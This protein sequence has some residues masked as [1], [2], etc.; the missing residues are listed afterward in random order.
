MS[1]INLLSTGPGAFVYHLL[2]FLVLETLV[3]VALIEYRRARNPDH[4]RILWTFGGLMGMRILLLLGEP[5][6][7]AVIAPILNGIELASLTLLGWAFLAPSSHRTG[8]RYLV[9]GLGATLLCT[10]T[11]LPGW[12]RALARFPY[13]L[14]LAFWQ[15]TFWYAVS[16]ILALAPALVLLRRRRGERQW[17]PAIAFGALSLGFT[18]LCMASL[19]LTVSWSDISAYTLIGIGRLINMQSYPLFAVAVHH[20]ALQVYRKPQQH[21]REEMPR[22]T[23]TLQ[24]LAEARHPSGGPLDLDSLLNRVV[25][26]AAT[27]MNVDICAIFLAN[28]DEPDTINLAAQYPLSEHAERQAAYALKRHK[29][30]TLNVETNNPRLQTLYRLL[31][32]RETGPTVI[33]PILNQHRPLGALVVGNNHSQ[34][35]FDPNAIRMCQDIAGQ[36]AAVLSD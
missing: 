26:G 33:Q 32:H 17:L 19:F 21:A 3:G 1:L 2:I 36:V 18:T 23:P 7:P 28:P 12:Y 5:L 20:A 24:F 30:L 9:G 8:K 6:G 4:R 11:F 13:L 25:E 14:Y 35:V 16:V 27:T 29:Q 10:V 15:Q 34:R 22:Q 31:G